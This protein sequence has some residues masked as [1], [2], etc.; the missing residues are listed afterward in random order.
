MFEI[1]FSFVQRKQEC[2]KNLVIPQRSLIYS[3]TTCLYLVKLKQYFLPIIRCILHKKKNGNIARLQLKHQVD[4]VPKWF[5]NQR[6]QI[7]PLKIIAVLF[8]NSKKK[9]ISI[10][11]NIILTSWTPNIKYLG[12]KVGR[13]LNFRRN[14]KKN[15]YG[16]RY[17]LPS[18]KQ[19]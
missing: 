19:T 18:P 13:Q 14:I 5:K 4:L 1:A 12:V 7:N 9:I 11:L 8:S 2:R 16:H 6:S 15:Y 3:R 17:I 10:V